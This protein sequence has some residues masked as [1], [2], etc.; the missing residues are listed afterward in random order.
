MRRGDPA[1]LRMTM[2]ATGMASDIPQ[3]RAAVAR[4]LPFGR[5][6]GIALAALAFAADAGAQDAAAVLTRAAAAARQQNY[7]GTILYQR[8]SR[9]QTSR[10][11]HLNERR[12]RAVEA[13]QPGRAAARGDSHGER[14]PLLLLGRQGRPDRVARVPQRL[15][16]AVAAAAEDAA[17]FLR[18]AQGGDRPH[19]RTGRS[20][21]DVHAQGRQ[22]LPAQALDR[23]RD[24]N[25][26]QGGAG[27]RAQ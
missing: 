6:A 2:L 22:S 27:Q 9:N 17:R 8:G 4:A 18:R 7:T 24:G 1:A 16:D 25:P 20:G 23:P 11:V 3:P 21:V 15:P 13:R 10:L 19:C 26:A 12:D 5:L 14:S